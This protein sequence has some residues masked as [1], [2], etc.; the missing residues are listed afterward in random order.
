[1]SVFAS[2]VL[3]S[4][5]LVGKLDVEGV[6]FALRTVPD[7]ERVGAILV[8]VLKRQVAAL[9]TAELDQEGTPAGSRIRADFVS[10]DFVA[11]VALDLHFVVFVILQ[12]EDVK[13]RAGIAAWRAFVA[14]EDLC[15]VV[16]RL[17]AEPDVFR[18]ALDIVFADLAVTFAVECDDLD[19]G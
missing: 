11:V 10:R 19:L 17:W 7:R 13:Q 18:R 1:N 8:E 14:A 16:A 4:S 9:V 2:D 12:R 3:Q 6:V 5:M 15:I